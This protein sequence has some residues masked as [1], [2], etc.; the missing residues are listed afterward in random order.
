MEHFKRNFENHSTLTE[1]CTEYFIPSHFVELSVVLM[2]HIW[3]GMKEAEAGMLNEI[4]YFTF[5]GICKTYLLCQC[6]NIIQELEPADS[7]NSL[8][9]ALM[10][11]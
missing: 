4:M 2:R 10:P 8:Q 1:E 9:K 6:K 5:F 11:C 7:R 3:I